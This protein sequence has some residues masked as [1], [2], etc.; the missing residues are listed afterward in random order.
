[1]PAVIREGVPGRLRSE[2]N[3][4]GAKEE[5]SAGSIVSIVLGAHLEHMLPPVGVDPRAR[6]LFLSEARGPA[7]IRVAPAPPDSRGGSDENSS[8]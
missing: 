6:W 8:H 5:R 3:T 2:E 7:A 1:M 4:A